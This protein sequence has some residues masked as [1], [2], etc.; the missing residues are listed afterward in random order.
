MKLR[1]LVPNSYIHVSVSD[2][3]ISTIGLPILLQ[4][5]RW[6]DRRNKLI[7]H[8]YMNVEIWE[9][10][11]VVSFMGIHKSDLVCSALVSLPGNLPYSKG[12]L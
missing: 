4:I 11:R 7:A 10:G 12:H 5:N 3:Y 9:Q 6:T 8:R 2:L 1:C